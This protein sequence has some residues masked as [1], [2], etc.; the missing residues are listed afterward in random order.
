M[1]FI[2][3]GLRVYLDEDVGVLL[4]TLLKAHGLDCETALGT[5]HAGWPDEEHLLYACQSARVIVTHNRTG[6]EDLAV[7]WC[8]FNKD[9]MGIVLAIRRTNTYS[10][11]R[12]VLP[13]LSV[14]D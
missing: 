3:I 8:R 12:R 14:F 11:I 2:P 1:T 6:F 9:H 13:A 10:L 7:E 4:A 5:G